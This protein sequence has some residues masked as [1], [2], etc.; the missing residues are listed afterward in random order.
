MNVCKQIMFMLSLIVYGCAFNAIAT[1]WDNL[2]SEQLELQL[3][4]K[5]AEGKYS[6]KGA[7]S[8]LVCHRKNEKSDGPI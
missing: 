8:C 3:N 2:N 5:F 4:E 6:P 1:P 7:D